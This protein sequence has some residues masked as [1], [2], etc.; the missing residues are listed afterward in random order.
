MDVTTA[1]STPL[2]ETQVQAA[3]RNYG[4]TDAKIKFE[5]QATGLTPAALLERIVDVQTSLAHYQANRAGA[6][7][8]SSASPTP[9]QPAASAHTLAPAPVAAA[10]AAA[11][12][13]PAISSTELRERIMALL[14]LESSY[15]REGLALCLVQSGMPITE[16]RATLAAAPREQG[17]RPAIDRA[18]ILAQYAGGAEGAAARAK[19]NESRSVA[20]GLN[21]QK[22]YDGRRAAS[23]QPAD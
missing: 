8:A 2:S 23:R 10:P 15:G 22:I 12:P 18:G 1:P 11:K 9:A 21:P 13:P 3:L 17:T 6:R 19:I 14:F 5:L 20:G 7:P 4:L 16:A